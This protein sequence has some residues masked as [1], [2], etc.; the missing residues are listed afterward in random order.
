MARTVSA[1]IGL[2]LTLSATAVAQTPPSLDEVVA[3][4]AAY[5]RAYAQDYAATIAAEHYSQFAGRRT[6]ILDSEFGIVRLPGNGV[7]WLGLRDVVRVDGKPVPDRENRLA[8]VFGT[9]SST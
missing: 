9:A 5:M 3:R 7:L 2:L 1:A 6:T 8:E 4:L